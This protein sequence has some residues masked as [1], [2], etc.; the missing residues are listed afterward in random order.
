MRAESRVRLAL[1][2][3]RH[4]RFFAE[5]SAPATRRRERFELCFECSVDRASFA[6]ALDR[7]LETLFHGCPELPD[8]HWSTYVACRDAHRQSAGSDSR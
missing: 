8:N 5:E 4:G 3:P 6:T 7:G 1:G 2:P